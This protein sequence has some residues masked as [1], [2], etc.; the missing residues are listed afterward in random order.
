MKR[1]LPELALLAQGFATCAH[2]N[3]RRKYEDAPRVA[4]IVAEY[5]ADES[6]IAAA[7][8]HD[9]LDDTDVTADEMC[10][11]LREPHHGS[12]S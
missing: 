8:T 3:Q 9:V 10:R 7:L 2:R 4:N 12:L 5:T 6:A 1:A 11:V